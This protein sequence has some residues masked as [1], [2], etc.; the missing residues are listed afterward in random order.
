MW[1]EPWPTIV[2]RNVAECS[3][4]VAH[5]SEHTMPNTSISSNERTD[6]SSSQRLLLCLHPFPRATVCVWSFCSQQSEPWNRSSR[7]CLTIMIGSLLR[8]QYSIS[9]ISAVGCTV[10]GCPPDWVPIN[11]H[12]DSRAT[13]SNPSSFLANHTLSIRNANG[14]KSPFSKD[15]TR[16]L[17]LYFVVNASVLILFE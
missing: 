2:S 4:D 10:A 15:S 9:I 11:L 16:K 5:K 1:P 6:I 17:F 12:Y 7:L 3:W 8:W 14:D 13:N